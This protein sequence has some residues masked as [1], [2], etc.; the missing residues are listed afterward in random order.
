M[1]VHA[2]ATH[3]HP[4]VVG[5]DGSAASLDA[6]DRAAQE[7]TLRGRRLHIVHA[8]SPYRTA[9]HG[10]DAARPPA[11]VRHHEAEYIIADAVG[12]AKADN[13]D[14][15]VTGE[16]ITGTA[17]AVLL[18]LSYAAC[19]VVIGSRGRG[20]FAG[21]LV[22][23]VAVRLAAHAACPILVVRGS[24]DAA[25]PVLLGV[26]GSPANDGA[27]GF[28]FEEAAM[29]GVPLHA[30]HIWTPTPVRTGDGQPLCYDLG[31]VRAEAQR[32]LAESLVGWHG[33]YPDVAVERTL[34]QG[35]VRHTLIE[36][37]RDAQLVVVGTR[38]WGGF[39]GLVLGSASQGLL[40]DAACPVV[41]VTHRQ[42]QPA[43]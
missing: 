36:A 10:P 38:G 39:A 25:K 32:V 22:G 15:P 19:L 34:T 31:D 21:L 8:I 2:E 16:V 17:T 26:D 14:M 20:G 40:H 28:A 12:R 6:V 3:V 30:L 9:T 41:V 43:P 7:A 42:P 37:T 23:S 35:S 1:S 33:K 18:R 27:V 11:D 24:V 5:V 29:R 4:V 13:P